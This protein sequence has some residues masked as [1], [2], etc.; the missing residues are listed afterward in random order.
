MTRFF[1][2]LAIIIAAIAPAAGERSVGWA[3]Q[4]VTAATSQIGVTTIYDPAYVRIAFPGGDVARER[5]VCTDVVV[6]AYR[7][8]FGADLQALVS[9]DMKASFSSYPRRWG[10]QRPDSNIDHRRVGNLAAYFSRK[11]QVLPV[12][13]EGK[14]Y[15]PGDIV[16]QML[17]GN[18]PHIAII[19]DK[20]GASGT[21]LVIHNIGRGAK[22]EDSLFAFPITGHYRYA[23]PG[24]PRAA[25]GR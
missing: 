8:A 24:K 16:T 9:A 7:D 4:L 1:A 15:L 13:R 21:P 22:L 14:D 18:L 10:L 5:G 19:S 6:R 23:P 17:P 3:T 11:G 2:A 20:E 25:G 12:T